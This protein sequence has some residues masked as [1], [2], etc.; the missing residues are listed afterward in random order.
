[1]DNLQFE[2]LKAHI[3]QELEAHSG[4]KYENLLAITDAQA[5]QIRLKE[6]TLNGTD[7]AVVFN[8]TVAISSTEV[9]VSNQIQDRLTVAE[10]EADFDVV[11]SGGTAPKVYFLVSSNNTADTTGYN[12]LAKY[13]STPYL[14]GNGQRIKVKLN[15]KEFT[16]GQYIK[17][18][19]VNSDG[20][21][22][23]NINARVTIK[24]YPLVPQ[25]TE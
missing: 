4:N 20:T 10:I 3:T 19:A 25:A 6:R 7:D 5:V 11:P 18:Y 16:D 21:N 23:Y 13:S 12:L 2:A 1:M 9:L 22:A 15:P 17:V 14:T 8:G 24:T